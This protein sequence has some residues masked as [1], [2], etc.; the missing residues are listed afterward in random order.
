MLDGQTEDAAE[1]R[2]GLERPQRLTRSVSAFC[3]VQDA[4]SR[5]SLRSSQEACDAVRNGRELKETVKDAA[6]IVS[7]M[8]PPS[9][10]G[11]C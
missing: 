11:C 10:P 4:A 9:I 6:Q 8:K 7:S 2:A 5:P 3:A 1:P